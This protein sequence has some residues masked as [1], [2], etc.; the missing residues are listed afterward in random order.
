M[1]KKITFILLILCFIFS[2]CLVG[3]SSQNPSETTTIVYQSMPIRFGSFNRMVEASDHILIGTVKEKETLKINATK[4]GYSTREGDFWQN[5]TSTQVEVLEVF[6]GDFKANDTIQV[7]YVGGTVDGITEVYF[8]ELIGDSL[9]KGSTYLL[10][11]Y[12]PD[13]HKDKPYFKLM[14]ADHDDSVVEIKD[15]RLVAQPYCEF[16]NVPDGN[17]T[18]MSKEQRAKEGTSLAKAKEMIGQ[19]I[20][21]NAKKEADK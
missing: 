11:F 9:E 20:Q 19:A 15:E 21:E 16:W 17:L 13:I 8:E 2:V 18:E 1:I 6:K 14:F 12:E 7:D 3:C 4:L 5:I 10:F